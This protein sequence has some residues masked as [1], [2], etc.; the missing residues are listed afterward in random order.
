[1]R[2]AYGKCKTRR[3]ICIQKKSHRNTVKDLGLLELIGFDAANVVRV[4]ASQGSDEAFHLILEL[5]SDGGGAL[6][7]ERVSFE[8]VGHDAVGA[9]TSKLHEVHKERVLVLFKESTDVVG[10]LP[11]VVAHGE[12]G[13]LHL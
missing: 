2:G 12:S 6:L 7:V 5:N 8:K 9:A 11:S 1:M 10:D 4:A 3:Y 13:P